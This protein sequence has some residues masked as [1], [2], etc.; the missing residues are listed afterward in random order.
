MK[1]GKMEIIGKLPINPVLFVTGKASGY[2]TWI[3][4]I[5][6]MLNV[7]FLTVHSGSLSKLAALVILVPGIFLLIISSINLGR[8]VRIGL[9]DTRTELRQSGIYKISR[10]PMYLGL[11]LVT[12]SSMIYT[13]NWIVIILGI[14]S[15]IIYHYIILGEEEFLAKR[16]GEQYSDFKRKVSRY[17]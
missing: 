12:L 4:A 5:L 10:N 3:V 16:F 8:A 15:I 1:G 6:S 9:P 11:H 17:L 13:L 14:Y 7:N 2:L